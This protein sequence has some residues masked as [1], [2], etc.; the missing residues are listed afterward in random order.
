M[1]TLKLLANAVSVTTANQVSTKSRYF[2]ATTT[3]STLISVGPNSSVI[4]A[5]AVF[6]A[7]VYNVA[8]NETTD[9]FTA[10]VATSFTPIA[11]S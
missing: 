6:P 8:K 10:N 4:V 3:A 2:M 5:S 11:A 7:G 1:K 9:F